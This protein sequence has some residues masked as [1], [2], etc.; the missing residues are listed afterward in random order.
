MSLFPR[1]LSAAF[2]GV[3]LSGVLVFYSVA[4]PAHA[5]LATATISV[6]PSSGTKA[7]DSAFDVDLL[8]SAGGQAVAGV[9]LI[10]THSANLR[11]TG[12]DATDSVFAEEVR[13]ATETGS[14]VRLTRLRFDTGY[15]A[16]GGTI[17]SLTFNPESTGTGTVSID[18]ASSTVL[19]YSDGSNIL[20]GISGGSFTLVPASST[21]SSTSSAALDEPAQRSGGG[22]RRSINT[23]LGERSISSSSQRNA[24]PA[25]ESSP[26]R[27]G[28]LFSDVPSGAWFELPI[29]YL[30]NRGIISGYADAS[31]NSLNQFGPGDSVTYA[32]I[33]KMAL[34]ATGRRESA[35]EPANTSGRST[36]ASGWIR[37][38]EEAAL[39]LFAPSLDVHLPA[40]RGAVVQTL[41]EAFGVR[42]DEQPHPFQD[43]TADHPYAA[44]L[45]AAYQLGVVTG[46]FANDGGPLNTVRP[47]EHINRAEAAAL[48][49]RLLHLGISL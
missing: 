44:A 38:A 5:A 42:I 39:S 40:S 27:Q 18:L 11:F 34:G 7:V 36:W 10:V 26:G 19:A 46:D 49:F 16:S 9:D 4:V 43:L 37:A 20:Q 48:L 25:S 45:S 17:I 6:S 41:L 1:T 30:L 32:Q 28:R 15:S 33:A 23:A 47:D 29:R 8:L 14:D 22:G 2:V 24:I 13:A 12:S 21:P 31:G 3:V 35:T